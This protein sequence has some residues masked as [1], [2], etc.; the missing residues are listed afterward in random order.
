MAVVPITVKFGLGYG[1][2]STSTDKVFVAIAFFA[3]GVLVDKSTISSL[4]ITLF[5][6][7]G[8][9]VSLATG[10]L[11]A[12]ASQG[13]RYF[14]GK[15]FNGAAGAQVLGCRITGSYSDGGDTGTLE[16][17]EFFEL[18]PAT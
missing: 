4:D 3:D 17:T 12:S 11:T 13:N 16:E 9:V 5:D 2:G 6:V 15:E 7:L 8:D 14:G 10:D 18:A 1:P